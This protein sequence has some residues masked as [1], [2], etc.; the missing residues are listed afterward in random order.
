MSPVEVVQ[1]HISSSVVGNADVVARVLVYQVR[2]TETQLLKT[3]EIRDW[4]YTEVSVEVVS[5]QN[6]VKLRHSAV[7]QMHSAGN[8]GCRER[9]FLRK[10]TYFT[11]KMPAENHRFI[12]EFEIC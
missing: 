11:I 9:C 1:L 10:K 3:R 5:R 12:C 7:C 2:S 6:L 4:G 8:F